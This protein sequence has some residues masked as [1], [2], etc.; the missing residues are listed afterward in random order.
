MNRSA[1]VTGATGFVGSHLAHALLD[2]GWRVTVIVRP[3]SHG[4]RRDALGAG[5]AS[6][7]E[8]DGTIDVLHEILR[9]AAPDVVFH[10]ATLF[11]G[12]HRP[13]DVE[14]LVHANVLFGAQV[15]EAMRT[16]GARRIV[17]AGTAWEHH[18]N[19]EYSPVSLYA[20]TKAA[21]A[22]LLA[23]YTEV[24]RFRAVV[25]DLTDTYG[26]GDERPK[27]L[28][29]LREAADTGT[30]LAMNAGEPYIDLLHVS[31][32]VAAFLIGAER[33]LNGDE[34]AL[35]RWAVRP[36]RP[37]RLRDLVHRFEQVLSRPIPV[38]WGARPYRAREAFTPWTSG[39]TLPGW[40][41]RV[42]LDDGLRDLLR[43]VHEPANES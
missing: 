23:Y 8:F 12:E 31:D 7:A 2:A 15:L 35:E 43:V 13:D 32:A 40:S 18:G 14:P 36:G 22:A 11:R 25:L 27:L 37:I 19:R 10:L 26:T 1:V 6:L 39:E 17:S 41:P 33:V 30:S 9:R 21:F 20:A 24:Q 34:P 3:T 42:P 16:T 38:R 29:L 5:G 28:R 4:P